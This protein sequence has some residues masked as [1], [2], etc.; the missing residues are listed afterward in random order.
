MSYLCY[1]H[2]A[3]LFL[4]ASSPTQVVFTMTF[5]TTVLIDITY[6]LIVGLGCCFLALMITQKNVKIV[7]LRPLPSHP[8]IYVDSID[9]YTR[10]LVSP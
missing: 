8:D 6:G 9:I 2:G 10:M 5:L 4:S 3:Y 7:R 1:I